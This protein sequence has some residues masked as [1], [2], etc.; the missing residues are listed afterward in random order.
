MRE[1]VTPGQDHEMAENLERVCGDEQ[2]EFPEK[3]LSW[4]NRYR[5][6]LDYVH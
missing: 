5:G 4:R 2:V 1:G 6:G 3:Q